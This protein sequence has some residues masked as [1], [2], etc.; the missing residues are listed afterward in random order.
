MQDVSSSSQ[1]IAKPRTNSIG[2]R[3]VFQVAN[4]VASIIGTEFFE[5]LVTNIGKALSADCVYLGE[6]AG[7]QLERLRTLAIWVKDTT[8]TETDY[9]LAGSVAAQVVTGESWSCT[10]GVLKKFPEDALLLQTE[11]QACI[12]VPLLD[13]KR[14]AMGV[15]LA[16]FRQSLD[17][18]RPTKSMLETFAP[19]AAVEL[20]RKQAELAL[21]ESEQR[22]H[23]FISQNVDAM[24]RIEFESPISTDLSEEEQI[25]SIY[26]R[27]Y[28]AECNEAM[29]RLL[30]YTK[31]EQL[32]G[33]TFEDLTR[34]ADPRLK[35]DIRSAVQSGYRFD[36]VERKPIDAD[37]HP[38]HVL[39]TQWCVVE[40]GKLIRIW[41]TLRD[42]TELKVVA[43][44]LQDSERRLSELI[45]NVHLL[46]VMWDGDGA[47]TYCNDYFS[48]FTGWQSGDLAGKN[49]FDLMVPPAERDKL[50]AEFASTRANSPAP[51]HF[52]STLLGKDGRS[53]LIAWESTIIHDSGG[54][55]TGLAGV[56]RDIT[57]YTTLKNELSQSQKLASMT[58][59]VGRLVDDFTSVL[60]V[61]SAYSVI[62]LDGKQETD[63]AYL[64][65]KGI[66]NAAEDGAAIAKQLDAFS[67]HLQIHP[68]LLDLN[69]LMEEAAQ[70]LQPLLPENVLLH[71]ALEPSTGL[72]HADPSLLQDAVLHLAA[73][74]I[75]AM[76]EGG[77]LTFRTSNSELSTGHDNSL[78][79]GSV[80]GPYVILSVA[81]TGG[82]MS[83]EARSHLF[84]P[85][86]T[87]KPGRAG[88]GLATV[89]GI[90][91][92][93]GGHIAVDTHAGTGTLVQIYFPRLQPQA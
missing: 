11:A 22:Y 14:Q 48:R 28:L 4:Q 36:T 69:T 60:T 80:P 52:E 64:P 42:I 26:D 19:R 86:F 62:L 76:P 21:R 67:R 46:T 92:Q 56:G 47:I 34:H 16:I 53:W 50:R 51:H 39:R 31:A 74:A 40:D 32:I 54:R 72:V 66:K 25:Q 71:L 1:R 79:S 38:R 45:E 33:M 17:N 85:F 49:W 73:N 89:Y 61:I 83:N 3:T 13:G 68:I 88:M 20:Q 78:L 75:E 87:T 77:N 29:A 8:H 44:A 58:R 90:V 63:P 82:G 37:G 57:A 15:M 35:D 7:G 24:W 43:E 41:G 5:S 70:T 55:V 93:S 59:S 27:G 18:T 23:A 12:A 65:L 6:F 81:D 30:G 2:Q 9:V 91:E 10:R 84:E